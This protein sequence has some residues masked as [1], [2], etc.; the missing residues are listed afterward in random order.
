MRLTPVLLLLGLIVLGGCTTANTGSQREMAQVTAVVDGDTLRLATG[1]TVRLLD[2]NTPEDGNPYHAAAA[3]RLRELTVNRT[4][5][6]ESGAANT[7]RYGRLLRYV[8]VN[9]TLVNAELVRDGLATTY[10]VE[11]TGNHREQL[12]RAMQDAREQGRGMWSP[13][14]TA[15]CITVPRFTWDAPGNDND[16]LDREAVTFRN[17]CRTTV[18]LADWTVKDAGTST[19]TFPTTTL[20]PGRTV[21]LHTGQG[22]PNAT[23]V[24]WGRTDRAVWNNDGDSLYLRDADG[25]LVLYRAYSGG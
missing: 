4:V 25:K 2:I 16:R 5:Q 1:A 17:T 21:T 9:G 24:Y 12:D 6:L 10:Y 19:Y 8:H 23:D 11:E 3:R 18:Q 22:T 15:D 7:G 13:S 14:P 20:Q